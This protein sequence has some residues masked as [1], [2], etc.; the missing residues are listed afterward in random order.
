MMNF[1]II[2]EK[3]FKKALKLTMK[4]DKTKLYLFGMNTLQCLQDIL[5]E[6]SRNA[7]EYNRVQRIIEQRGLLEV[8]SS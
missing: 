8:V 3:S 5:N 2:D 4:D 7:R 1:E 6:Y